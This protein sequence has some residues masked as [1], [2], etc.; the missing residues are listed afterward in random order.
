VIFRLGLIILAF[1]ACASAQLETF[2]ADEW[3]IYA[4]VIIVGEVLGTEVVPD[5][6]TIG[7]DSEGK[8]FLYPHSVARIAVIE[9][10]KNIDEQKAVVGDTISVLFQTDVHGHRE[11][12]SG[13]ATSYVM[14]GNNLRTAAEGVTGTFVL[15]PYNGEWFLESN[16]LDT[17]QIKDALRRIAP[18]DR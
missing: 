2:S 8:P 18:A 6:A 17:Q 7:G 1:S 16:V 13:A 14:S 5:R 4:A 10:L 3:T 9:N 12:H 15:M 11:M